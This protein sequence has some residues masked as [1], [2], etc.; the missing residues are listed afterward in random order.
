MHQLQRGGMNCVAA[1]IADEIDVLFE[2][3]HLHTGTR[4][5]VTSHHSGGSAAYDDAA[6]L[7][8]LGHDYL[9]GALISVDNEA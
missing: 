6:G 3:R 8:F 4:Q 2:H 9:A 1:E 5:Q 7:D